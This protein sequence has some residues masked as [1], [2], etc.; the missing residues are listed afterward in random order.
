[1]AY[2]SCDH[3]VEEFS[4][5]AIIIANDYQDTVGYKQLT[6]TIK[7][8]EQLSA[9]FSHVNFC[10]K[11][12]SNV[13]LATL[14]GI[15]SEVRSL[16]WD[17][18]KDYSCIAILFAGHGTQSDELVLQDGSLVHPRKIISPLLPGKLSHL[19]IV[20]KVFLIDA[21]RGSNT[22]HS[23]L[24][25]RGPS[26]RGGT[27][28]EQLQVPSEGNYLIARST[29]P[30]CKAYETGEIGG[31]WFHTLADY[32]LNMEQEM[33]LDDI[34]SKVNGRI[35]NEHGHRSLQQPERMTTINGVVSLKPNKPMF[36]ITSSKLFNLA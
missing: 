1:M 8:G 14:M 24:V 33:S 4:G 3:S 16:K 34:L 32:I 15:I 28:L 35:V 29:L 23:V 27:V 17:K 13:N 25:P 19:G 30:K 26:E 11:R 10:V 6:G 12:Y 20:P 21:C 7:D 5:L 22:T 36:D 9:A 31:L 18:V 2:S